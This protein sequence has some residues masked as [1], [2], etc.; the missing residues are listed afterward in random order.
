MLKTAFGAFLILHG[1]IHLTW[2]APRPDDPNYP[3]DITS[4][5]LIPGASAGTLKG[6]GMALSIGA[7]VL[8]VVA[9]LGVLGLIGLKAVWAGAAVAAAVLSAILIALFWRSWFVAGLILDAAIV[10]AVFMGWPQGA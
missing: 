10:V 5:P 3:F 1:L 9:G 4:S 8:F 7:A 2:I 6:V